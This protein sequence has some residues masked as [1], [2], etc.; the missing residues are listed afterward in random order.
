M[1]QFSPSCERNKGPILA[2]LREIITTP[3]RV[4]EIGSGSG[5]HAVHFARGLP[6]VTWLPTDTAENLPSIAAWRAEAHLPNLHEPQA[7]DLFAD[8]WPV[9]QAQ[10]LVCINTIH[11]ISWA[12]VEKLFDGAG[13][14]LLPGGILYVYG[15]YRYAERPLEPSNE[16]FDRWL[17][18]RD[19]LSGVRLF[20]DVNR[21]AE[22]KGFVLAGDRAMPANNRSL[23][24]K[25]N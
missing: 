2:V 11:I 3:G 24:W 20:E 5:Q 7:L 4:L 23:W 18:A 19:P 21:L 16:E 25:K 12:S 17:K 13:R 22:Q 1:K 15:P 9:E 6:H 14:V 8:A 10:A